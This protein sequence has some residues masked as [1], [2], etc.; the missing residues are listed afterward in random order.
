LF[1]PAFPSDI[2]REGKHLKDIFNIQT[3]RI[4][5]YPFRIIKRNENPRYHMLTQFSELQIPELILDFKA[6][7]AIPFDSFM[8]NYKEHYLATT[9]EL[10]REDL[11][12]RFAFYLNRVGLPVIATV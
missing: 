1:S 12:Q 6:Y 10:F 7:Y 8:E 5:T 3:E 9:N 11:S 2:I 4:S